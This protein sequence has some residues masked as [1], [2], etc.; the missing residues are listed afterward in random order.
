M[1][2][3]AKKKKKKYKKENHPPDVTVLYP[4]PIPAN[5]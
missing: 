4:V 2:R 1:V 3:T 5:C